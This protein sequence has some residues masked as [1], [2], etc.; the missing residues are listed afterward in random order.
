MKAI[1]WLRKKLYTFSIHYQNNIVAK[2][3]GCTRCFIRWASFGLT[4][5]LHPATGQIFCDRGI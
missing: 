1:I 5:D 4:N 2:S 3:I